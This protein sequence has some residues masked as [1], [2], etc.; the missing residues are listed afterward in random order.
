MRLIDADA[1]DQALDW[2]AM[3]EALRK[4]FRGALTA[5]PRHH[6]DVAREGQTTAT[7]LIMPAW[8]VN[9]PGPDSYLGTKIVGVFP[10]NGRFGLSSIQGA[11]LLQSGETGVGLAVL[12]GGRLTAW[13]TAG[14]SALAASYLARPD[15][16]RLC[17]VG[18]GALAPCLIRAHS[19][20]R[21]I[22]HVTI[23][24]HRRDSADRLAA[25]LA[26]GPWRVEAS[27]DLEAA[28]RA[29]DIVSCATLS[30]VALIRGAW[31]RAGQHV[32]LVGAFNR[33]MREADDD[34]IRRARVFVDT[35]AALTEGGDVAQAI[36]AQVIA[37]AD[38]CGDLADLCRERV[39]GRE[40][41]D[42]LTLF[43]SI[44]ASIEDLAAAILAWERTG[45]DRPR[46]F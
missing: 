16:R 41:P 12:D 30:R 35:P 44:G 25:E 2:P 15:A 43:K 8:S 37:K 11:Y 40:S 9:A 13:R 23:W 32:D 21:P 1:I 7:Q 33:R 18:A 31:L 5:P 17:L 42:E 6:L 34:V 38:V 3:I 39:H 10:D 26:G 24:N 20:V 46:P 22:S 28:V 29:A 14:A 45:A 27:D 19:A 36:D 4:A